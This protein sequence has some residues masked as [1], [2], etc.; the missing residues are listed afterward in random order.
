MDEAMVI[1]IKRIIKVFKSL[2][3]ST[4]LQNNAI[5]VDPHVEESST[6]GKNNEEVSLEDI[7]VHETTT[8]DVEEYKKTNQDNVC[9][10]N[11]TNIAT[12]DNQ[13]IINENE[14]GD[15]KTI[16]A[17]KDAFDNDFIRESTY[18][19][20]GMG[21][22][23]GA[24]LRG[25]SHKESGTECQDFHL[26]GQLG[27]EW[28]ALIVSDGAGSAKYSGRGSMAN[29]NIA[30]QLLSKMVAENRWI[31]N[32]VFPSELEWYIQCRSIF[33]HMK[34]IYRGKI[35]EME[36]GTR[37]TDFNATIILC[38]ITPNGLLTAHI[39]DGRMG[40]LSCEGE[41][42]ELMVPHKGEEA[43]QTL[44]LQN[45]W[46][47]PQVPAFKVGGVFVPE[48]RVVREIPNAIVLMSDGFERAS[49]EC[50]MF[51]KTTGR[52]EYIN[53]PHPEFMNPLIDALLEESPADRLQLLID[54]MDRGTKACEQERD[55]KTMLLV[56]VT[57]D[58]NDNIPC[59]D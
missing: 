52:Y 5:V 3:M 33:E 26:Y 8:N 32:D 27:K 39:G 36:D 25:K 50:V 59:C 55:D 34:L 9:D 56:I 51:N 31:E 13:E 14:V 11:E 16:L 45:S 17:V 24:S 40:Y 28:H 21:I 48:T 46:T 57:K 22:V 42:K 43:N 49:W 20:N 35:A 15:S 30:L 10:N 38:L 2:V 19:E 12:T 44:F 7:G 53:K 1:S 23:I 58:D 18:L 4:H 6:D 47:T 54:I 29:C 37:E 41:W